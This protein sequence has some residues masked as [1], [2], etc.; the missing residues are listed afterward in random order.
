[1]PLAD[2]PKKR[3]KCVVCKDRGY[4]RTVLSAGWRSIDACDACMKFSAPDRDHQALNA[5]IINA[6]RALRALTELV[7][8]D[9]WSRPAKED[10]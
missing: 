7:E 6:D 3:G 4:L 2:Y 1:M 8:A 10:A 9:D 5:Y